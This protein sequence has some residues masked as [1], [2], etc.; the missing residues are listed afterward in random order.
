MAS[1]S[2]IK[3]DDIPEN[4]LTLLTMCQ[5]KPKSLISKAKKIENG[6]TDLIMDLFAQEL[7]NANI[8]ESFVDTMANLYSVA[9]QAIPFA[10][11]NTTEQELLS[12]SQTI[13][14][15]ATV[16]YGL[17]FGLIEDRYLNKKIDFTKWNS[18]NIIEELDDIVFAL[19]IYAADLY[20]GKRVK[21][22]DFKVIGIVLGIFILIREAH[23]IKGHE[24]TKESDSIWGNSFL[25]RIAAELINNV[26]YAISDV[27]IRKTIH[28]TAGYTKKLSV[29][30]WK[31][32]MAE[33]EE[34]TRKVWSN[35]PRKTRPE[36]AKEVLSIQRKNHPELLYPKFSRGD[37][38][39]P[40][41][42]EDV[43][44]LIYR[45]EYKNHLRRFNDDI[46]RLNYLLEMPDLHEKVERDWSD[47]KK[48][49]LEKNTLDLR[50]MDFSKL[51]EH[52]KN[53]IKLANRKILQAISKDKIPNKKFYPYTFTIEKV[54]EI[55][56]SLAKEYGH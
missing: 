12:Y 18:K 43:F 47:S 31:A 26:I 39:E 14:A 6:R 56:N 44:R 35:D 34:L 16:K 2:K 38:I 42:V 27:R 9:M 7:R 48:W 19:T 55:V 8:K 45:N 41:T 23:Y 37:T 30:P 50:K 11:K 49:P 54:R 4:L 28:Q 36:V 33:T 40:E 52:G 46:E 53:K 21:I 25:I 22:E 1:N 10:M 5:I 3:K 13:T 17:D 24:E 20:R 51:T 15:Y 32:L 29:K